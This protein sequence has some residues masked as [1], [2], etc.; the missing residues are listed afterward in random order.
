MKR[1]LYHGSTS[2]IEKPT[3]GIG[4]V[5]ND[6]GL[7]FYCTSSKDLA[8]EWAAKRTGSGYINHYYLRDDTLK[9]LDLTMP[10]YNN[11]IY[12]VALLMNNRELSSDIK[13][14]YPR[15]LAYLKAKY[16]IDVSQY[17]VVI[18]YRA[19]DS[20]FQFPEAFIR[21]Q[22]TLESL[23]IIFSAGQLGKQYVL[24]S[25]KAFKALKFDSFEEVFENSKRDYY[26]RKK[27]AGH[28][29]KELLEEDR[30]K[31]GIRLID[32]VRDNE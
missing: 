5:H 9:I 26:S 23:N 28:K 22:I 16:L 18:G 6:Y 20:Y 19:D 2:I 30:Y 8:K 32:L 21:S 17:D 3:F 15:E 13:E 7:G 29:F 27:E 14:S 12:W 4:N 11:V 10:P 24:I 1:S 31:K 25:E